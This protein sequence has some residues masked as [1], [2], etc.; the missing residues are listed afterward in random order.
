MLGIRTSALGAGKEGLGGKAC[1][2][3]KIER[4]GGEEGP[5]GGEQRVTR[6]S[7]LYRGRDPPLVARCSLCAALPF[8]P[9]PRSSER[10]PVAASRATSS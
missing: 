5:S 4:E 1:A 8:A 2:P 3:Y 7:I 10:M 9:S 6:G